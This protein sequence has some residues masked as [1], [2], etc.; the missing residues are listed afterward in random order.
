MKTISIIIPEGEVIATSIIST[1]EIFKGVNEYLRNKNQTEDDFFKVESVGL[2]KIIEK[3][4]GL[5]SF[6]P[7]KL[8]HEVK[9]TDLIIITTI[10][11]NI[12]EAIQQNTDF[13]PWIVKMRKNNHCEIA[14]FC[15]GV[16]LL[17]ETELLDNKSAS[18]HWFFAEA[19]AN[20]YPKINVIPEIII[21]DE[22]GREH[23]KPSKFPFE[24][25]RKK[26]GVT[27]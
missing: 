3:Y 14:S 13:I 16:F 7:S 5:I 20:K 11:G 1:I 9:T 12:E 24:V 4:D 19:F 18:A 8:I 22:L 10:A 15:N 25:I 2:N 26:L 27:K 17:A 6:S 21:T 23:W